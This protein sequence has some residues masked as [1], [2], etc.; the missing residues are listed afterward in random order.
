MNYLLDTNILF[1]LEREAS[2][3]KEKVAALTFS[4][5][6]LPATTTMSH[7]EY[8]TGCIE[9]PHQQDR[10]EFI[11]QFRC[12]TLSPISAKLWAQLANKYA[13]KGRMLPIIDLM[14]AAIAIEHGLCILTKD[15]GFKYIDEVQKIVLEWWGQEL[16]QLDLIPIPQTI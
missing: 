9:S 6:M 3:T 11:S 13:A 2:P 16:S 4:S 10:E 14:I 15:G 1:D 5:E 7:A 8:W 12:F